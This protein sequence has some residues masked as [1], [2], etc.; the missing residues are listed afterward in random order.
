MKVVKLLSV[1]CTFAKIP[2]KICFGGFKHEWLLL[3]CWRGGG[4]A[5]HFREWAS[6]LAGK[7]TLD[8]IQIS[9]FYAFPAGV[10]HGIVR[11][12]EPVGYRDGGLFLRILEPAALYLPEM[13]GQILVGHGPQGR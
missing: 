4:L 7:V 3:Q 8:L 6:R 5:D 13:V 1:S 9:E 2:P 10:E 11:S 12:G